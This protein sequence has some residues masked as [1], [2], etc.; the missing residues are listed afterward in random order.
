MHQK[1][2]LIA[3]SVIS[4]SSVVAENG[5]FTAFFFFFFLNRGL[6]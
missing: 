4:L 2:A 6:R 3:D 1:C 5:N